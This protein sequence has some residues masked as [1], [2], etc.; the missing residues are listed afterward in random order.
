MGRTP[1]KE[2]QLAIDSYNENALVNA[3]AG[4]GKTWVLGNHV[5]HL[6]KQYNL[7]IS[8]FLI[9]TF[10]NAAANEMK[11]RIKEYILKDQDL[12]QY[13]DEVD[14]A[15]IQTFDAF[16]LFLVKKYHKYIGVSDDVSIGDSAIFSIQKHHYISEILDGFYNDDN[17]ILHELINTFCSRD[18]YPIYNLIYRIIDLY[19]KSIPKIDFFKQLLEEPYSSLKIKNY[20]NNYHQIVFD[21]YYKMIDILE[22]VES[23][24]SDYYVCVK[25][26]LPK[27]V[28]NDFVSFCDAFNNFRIPPLNRKPINKYLKDEYIKEVHSQ[29]KYYKEKV[30]G[31]L[32]D[33]TI[34]EETNLKII[35]NNQ[36]YL[37]F[38][39]DIAKQVIL[40]LDN[41]KKENNIYDFGDVSKLA[42]KL[43]DNK[44][45]L[46]M[47]KKEF[48]YI[49]VD[50][51]QDTNDIQEEFIK[52]LENNNV[53]M[54]GD[55]KQSIYRFRNA[56]C[57]IFLDKYNLY[58]SNKDA[59][60][61]ID[62]TLNFRSRPQIIED[63]NNMFSKLMKKGENLIDYSKGHYAKSGLRDY[64][65]FAMDGYNYG[66]SAI[67][68]DND[69]HKDK[70]YQAKLIAHDIKNKIAD[71]ILVYNHNGGGYRF[72]KYSDFAI[73]CETTTDFDVIE[74]VFNEYKIPLF[75]VSDTNIMDYDISLIIKNLLIMVNL[76]VKN[77]VL[78]S[79][80]KHSFASVARSFLYSYDD[81]KI[82]NLLKDTS[83]LKDEIVLNLRKIANNILSYSLKTLLK[84]IIFTTGLI[85]KI[86]TIGNYHSVHLV[87]NSLL[88]K[89]DSLDEIGY[90]LDKLI[91]FFDELDENDI[92][93]KGN[94]F[95][96]NSDVVTLINTHKSKGLEYT[97][98]Y[99]PF[100]NKR[101]NFPLNQKSVD[102]SVDF[103][104]VTN[105]YLNLYPYNDKTILLNLYK[106]NE[107]SLEI[108][109]KLRLLYVALT[110]AKEMA[111]LILPSDN[112]KFIDSVKSC[113]NFADMINKF[114]LDDIKQIHFDNVDDIE[115]KDEIIDGDKE[116]KLID[117]KKI[118]S[119]KINETRASKKLK[120]CVSEE[121]LLLGD[122]LHHILQNTDFVS[123]DTSFVTNE[124]HKMIID[125]VLKNDIFNNL[126]NATIL[127]EF[128]FNDEINH[129][130]GIID[131]LILKDDEVIIIDYKTKQIDDELYDKQLNS[132]GNYIKQLTNKNIKLY[133]LSIIDNKLKE[134][135]FNV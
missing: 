27:Y 93:F 127:K 60:H 30:D 15:H 10:T 100:L 48:K 59:G 4:S 102:I 116:F 9:M 87:I 79:N 52:K 34:D 64:K 39:I 22:S 63:I 106:M 117:P 7:K 37:K 16:N 110:R 44:E 118:S 55:V 90:D 11:T 92:D 76:L 2:Q 71:K 112:N 86:I 98:C 47:V 113:N 80:F 120:D 96:E 56:N 21:T 101:F 83:Y 132:Y 125:N 12:K 14:F 75:T 46:A 53:F 123:K 135:K 19:D 17:Q 131:C 105:N 89:V 57:E 29:I 133:L 5:L 69:A 32:N 33:L 124:N 62:M 121:K 77:E 84:E 130:N 24:Y 95:N 61:A 134:V 45:V 115:L 23:S 129:L 68:Y 70:E 42:L 107:K 38:L 114:T 104:L 65:L 119:N 88:N 20:F 43:L 25:A 108:D 74:K 122:K 66:V 8:D 99:Y 35:K 41:F 78:N 49:M 73:I 109:E 111:I 13:S 3:G 67:V 91:I 26:S 72:V 85:D 103:G 40:R 18:D 28:N 97:I 94:S 1:S 82:Y 126:D 31:L 58:S 128:P 6:M 50:E 51:Y 54:V 36:R 81:E